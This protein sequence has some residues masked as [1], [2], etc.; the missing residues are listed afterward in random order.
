AMAALR[1]AGGPTRTGE[2]APTFATFDLD[3]RPVALTDYRGQVVL[4]NFWASWCIP[5]RREFPLLREV[6][7]GEVAVLGVVFDDS[8]D[9]ARRFMREQGATWPGLIDPEGQIADAYG[10]AK[11]PG[12]PVT[13][14]VDAAGAL[15]GRHVG[16]ARRADL[17]RLVALA[18]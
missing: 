13:V 2:R 12:I 8:A 5:C 7:G 18:R 10:V 4:V 16:E 1:P 6:H 11:K 9:A 14:A 3:G 17:A 15:A